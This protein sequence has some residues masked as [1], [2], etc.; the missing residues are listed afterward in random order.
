ME[1]VVI[2]LETWIANIECDLS[3]DWC[4]DKITPMLQL[5][6]LQQARDLLKSVGQNN[7]IEEI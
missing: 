6:K 7:N 3:R 2:E 4:E 5:L 1:K